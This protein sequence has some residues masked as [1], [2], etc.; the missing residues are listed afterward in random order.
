MMELTYGY[1]SFV[2]LEVQ[3]LTIHLSAK[4]FRTELWEAIRGWFQTKY[5]VPHW[6]SA[7]FRIMTEEEDE[8]NY[9][10]WKQIGVDVLSWIIFHLLVPVLAE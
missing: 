9:P 5:G 10:R 3:G 4:L 1:E 6:L 7:P 2:Q 8:P